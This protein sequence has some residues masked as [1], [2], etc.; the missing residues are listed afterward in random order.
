MQSDATLIAVVNGAA[1]DEVATARSILHAMPMHRV[2]A[3]HTT[4]TNTIKFN[5]YNSYFMSAVRC[6]VR[7]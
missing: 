3:Q 7:A 4:L 1:S 2:A 6:N 5:T